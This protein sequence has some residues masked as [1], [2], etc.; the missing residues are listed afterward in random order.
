VSKNIIESQILATPET[1]GVLE[2]IIYEGTRKMLQAA[3]EAE[4]E[5]HLSRFKPLVDD[6]GK[7]LVVRNGTIPERTLLSGA[8][9]IPITRPRVDDRAVDA[10]AR[11]GFRAR[12]SRSSCAVLRASI[13]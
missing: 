1:R 13:R 8:G 12:Y 7:H 10:L 5:E 9:P 2:D 11:N 4:I 3:L 6:D